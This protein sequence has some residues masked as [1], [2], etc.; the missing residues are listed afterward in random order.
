MPKVTIAIDAEGCISANN[1]VGV[2]PQFFVI[3]PNGY[4]EVLDR[5]GRPKGLTYTLEVSDAELAAIQ[6]AAESC[7][8][9]AILVNP[10]I[11]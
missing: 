4:A 10:A 3:T 9:K 6:E 7:P 2:A 1:C 11:D 8:T 5:T